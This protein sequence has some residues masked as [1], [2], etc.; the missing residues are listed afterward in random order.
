MAMVEWQEVAWTGAC[1]A[2]V[3]VMVSSSS[4]QPDTKNQVVAQRPADVQAQSQPAGGQQKFADANDKRIDVTEAAFDKMEKDQR[5]AVKSYRKA[6]DQGNV[7]AQ[8]NLGDCYFNGKGVVK[9][10]REA[11]TWYR[12]AA[13]QGNATA[14]IGLGYCYFY[15][16]GV[17][18]DGVEAVKWYRKAAEQGNAAAQIGLGR[19]YIYGEGVE[20]DEV[21]AVKWYGKA[22]GWFRKAADQG[23]ADAHSISVAVTSWVRAWRE[24]NV[25]P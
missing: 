12:K 10:Q 7:E 16:E 14:Q 22:V 1:V 8:Y 21:E 13:E 20:K 5:E 3:A 25:K 19:C 2:Y 18:K 9:D 23:D 11:V 6:A 24:T 4:T 15:G 17:E